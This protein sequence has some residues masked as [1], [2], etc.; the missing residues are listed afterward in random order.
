MVFL[1]TFLSSLLFFQ[2]LDFLILF[3]ILITLHLTPIK[4]KIN[5]EAMR[6]LGSMG[7]QLSVSF[8][9]FK[10]AHGHNLDDRC[11]GRVLFILGLLGVH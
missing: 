5:V 7:M 6:S 1:L 9:L 4:F 8:C 11:L 3:H 10:V 2:T